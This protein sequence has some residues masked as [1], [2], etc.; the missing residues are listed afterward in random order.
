MQRIVAVDSGGEAGC[1]HGREPTE[2]VMRCALGSPGAGS[3]MK[4]HA[5]V[6]AAAVLALL[7]CGPRCEGGREASGKYCCWPGQQWS[8]E[9]DACVG[10]PKCPAGLQTRAGGCMGP[11]PTCPE[12][13]VGVGAASFYAGTSEPNKG[14]PVYLTKVGAFCIDR[15]EVTV[16][17][18][19]QC[20]DAGKCTA[21]MYEV[22]GEPQIQAVCNGLRED[23][24]NYP[25][26]CIN[27]PQADAYCR[28]A[29]KTLPTEE[30]W[31]LAAGRMD[32]RKFV[33]GDAPPNAKTANLRGADGEVDAPL[34]REN[35]GWEMTAPVGSFPA[36]T[37]PFGTV[38]MGGNVREWSSTG[39]DDGM[40]MTMGGE[41]TARSLA[42]LRER[43]AA[44]PRRDVS[45]AGF[46]CARGSTP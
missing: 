24:M 25:T 3:R 28:W 42:D 7:G 27:W 45:L 43:I 20:V 10:P 2:Q 46:R 14:V 22:P 18:Y 6:Y 40:R 31:L 17:A 37:G 41:H 15:T 33:W 38:D 35:D 32:G 34:Y 36:D 11:T 16:A 39:T 44:S 13:M 19:K 30:Q 5:T 9:R 8:E 21:P 29:T 26:N 4:A 12:D 23:R 1:C